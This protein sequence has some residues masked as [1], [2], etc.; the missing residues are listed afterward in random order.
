M[1]GSTAAVTLLSGRCQVL[2]LV[3]RNPFFRFDNLLPSLQTALVPFTHKDLHGVCEGETRT[4]FL[5][6]SRNQLGGRDVDA[7]I[8]T[9]VCS[10]RAESWM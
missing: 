4:G 8:S 10:S 1:N 3:G 7:L 9:S 6:A 5:H 2:L